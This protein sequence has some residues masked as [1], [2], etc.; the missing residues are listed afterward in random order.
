MT[1]LPRPILRTSGKS[2]A[3]QR[4]IDI[5]VED[6]DDD[7]FRV[8]KERALQ[9]LSE[10]VETFEILN[11]GVMLASRAENLEKVSKLFGLQPNIILYA[12]KN[13][14]IKAHD[15]FARPEFNKKVLMKQ[16]PPIPTTPTTPLT[17]VLNVTNNSYHNDIQLPEIGSPLV[18]ENEI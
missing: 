1:P 3:G 17:D 13:G 18:C 10:S 14:V 12:A 2:P 4:E 15:M 7:E 5:A 6:D 11:E 8:E 9:I 16:T